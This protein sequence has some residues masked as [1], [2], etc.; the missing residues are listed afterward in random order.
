[1][2]NNLIDTDSTLEIMIDTKALIF[3]CQVCTH[4]NF[5]SLRQDHKTKY[6]FFTFPPFLHPPSSSKSLCPMPKNFLVLFILTYLGRAPRTF[7]SHLNFRFYPAVLA[8]QIQGL[9]LKSWSTCWLTS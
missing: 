7:V 1:M 4:F 6:C 5:R 2:L 8:F 3:S 9:P